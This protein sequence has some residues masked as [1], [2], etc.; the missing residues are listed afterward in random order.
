MLI[1]IFILIAII[2]IVWLTIPKQP[3]RLLIDFKSITLPKT[4]NYFLACPTNYC[5]VSSQLTS[6]VFYMP[7]NELAKAWQQFIHQQPRVQLLKSNESNFQ[8]TYQQRTP[9]LRF[10]DFINVQLIAINENQSSIAL[11]SQSKYGYS[12]LGVNEKRVKQWLNALNK[13]G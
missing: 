6:P 7:V 12:D 5:N 8:F 10:P 9:Y 2:F 11:L 4:P 3:A 13:T 1:S